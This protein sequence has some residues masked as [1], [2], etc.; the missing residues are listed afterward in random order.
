MLFRGGRVD[1]ARNALGNVQ[2]LR[3]Q[4]FEDVKVLRGGLDGWKAAGLNSGRGPRPWVSRAPPESPE[5]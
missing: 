4:G 3:K 1:A 5:L 2:L